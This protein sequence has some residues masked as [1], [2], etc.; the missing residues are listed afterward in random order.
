MTFKDK[1]IATVKKIP[2]G[3]VTSYGTVASLV[4]SPRSALLV[5]E[6]LRNFSSKY[7]LPW[8]RVINSKGFISIKNIECPKS[9]QKALLES[10][11]VEVSSDFMVD[12]R[13]Y[14]WWG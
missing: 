8:Q 12:L 6:I 2:Y 13:K 14:G 4:G 9:L 1:V 10:E 7:N 5:G 3:R 11:G